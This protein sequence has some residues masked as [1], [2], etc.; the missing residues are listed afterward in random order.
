MW[1]LHVE[2]TGRLQF[3]HCRQGH[4]CRQPELPR[5]IADSYCPDTNT[6]YEFLGCFWHRQNCQ[7]FRDVTSLSGDTLAERYDGTMSR[8]EQITR[9]GFHVKMQWKCEFEEKRILL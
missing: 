9:A 2:V 3:V 8:L 1:L 4:E 7:S 6:V 5:L